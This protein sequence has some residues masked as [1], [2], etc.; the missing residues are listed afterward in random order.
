MVAGEFGCQPL[1]S[2]AREIIMTL[3]IGSFSI[4]IH[5]LRSLSIQAGTYDLLWDRNGLCIC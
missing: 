5:L 2:A 4:E 1:R 3:A